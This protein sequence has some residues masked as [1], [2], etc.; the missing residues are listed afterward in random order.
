M[1]DVW[2]EEEVGNCQQNYVLEREPEYHPIENRHKDDECE[3][4]YVGDE[5]NR[6]PYWSFYD[7]ASWTKFLE[8]IVEVVSV[9]RGLS[10]FG[11][12]VT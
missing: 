4:N 7:K 6:S 10:K 11:T 2:T 3:D 1:Q 9:K 8:E 12:G 5:T